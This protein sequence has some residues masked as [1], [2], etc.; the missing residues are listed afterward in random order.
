MAKKT[1]VTKAQQKRVGRK[2]AKINR[3]EKKKPKGKRRPMAQ[4]KAMAYSM[5]KRGKA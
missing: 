4:R 2:I 1:K 5:V 3:H